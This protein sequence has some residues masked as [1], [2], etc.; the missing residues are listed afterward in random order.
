MDQFLS[1]INIVKRLP[2]NAVGRDFVVG[3]LHGSISMLE[4][5]LKQVEFNEEKD[6][7][8]L[9]GDLADRGEDSMACL[10]L[11][12]NPWVHSVMG[13]H[14]EM[15]LGAVF[16]LFWPDQEMPDFFMGGRGL[17]RINGGQ[18]ADEYLT[19]DMPDEFFELFKKVAQ[20]P[21][22]LVVGEDENRFNVVHAELPDVFTD[23]TIDSLDADVSLYEADG[24]TYFRWTRNL[25][26]GGYVCNG[27]MREGL[28]KTYTGH[29]IGERVRMVESHICIDTGAFLSHKHLF[30]G[31]TIVNAITGYAITVQHKDLV[32]EAA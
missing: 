10:R 23:E 3:D 2:A 7:L 30:H 20:L 12:N 4:L 18:W 5:A 9:V 25:F 11:L 13:N 29:T 16:Q 21:H 6:R 22:I 32:R 17:F 24:L 14:E 8:F 27:G 28:S 15:L 1:K 31:L 19:D 26:N